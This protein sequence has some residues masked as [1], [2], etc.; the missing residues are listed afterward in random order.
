MLKD[1]TI[2]LIFWIYWTIVKR[3]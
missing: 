3:F 1:S 2:H